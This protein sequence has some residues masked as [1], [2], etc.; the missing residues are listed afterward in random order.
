MSNLDREPGE[1]SE[2]FMDRLDRYYNSPSERVYKKLKK[3]F[4]RTF[5]G[6]MD[7]AGGMNTMGVARGLIYLLGLFVVIVV[8]NLIAAIM[9]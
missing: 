8:L 4:P 2:E 6:S 1:T 9:S 3:R 5:K 7:E